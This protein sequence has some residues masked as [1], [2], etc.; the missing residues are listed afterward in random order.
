ML[1]VIIFSGNFIVGK[2]VTDTIPPF[3]LALL[4]SFIAFLCMIPIGFN[5]WKYF[6]P[7][8]GKEWKALFTMSLTGIV[9]FTGLVYSA[10]KHTTTINAAIVE[11]T[12]PVF[13]ILLGYIFLKE[14]FNKLQI[15]GT[16]LSLIGVIWIITKGSLEILQSLSF[17]VGDLVMLMAV[18][19]WAV[20]SL[21]VKRH[22]AKFPAYG[23]LLVMLFMATIILLPMAAIEWQNDIDIQ[24]N[25]S[26]ILG[27]L[28]VGFFPSILALIAWNK[29][30]GVIGPSRASVFLN[31]VPVFTT[32][33]A[34][35]FLDESLEWL[36][37]LGGLLVLIGV[38]LTTRRRMED[39]TGKPD[40]EHAKAELM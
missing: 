33:G 26:I 23:G 15:L 34:I 28:Y 24:W 21:L 38:Y 19:S 5:Q 40:E 29:A 8:W 22:N 27:L 18:I 13:A 35:L 37:V 32:I 9:L 4:R 20:Y 39:T 10:I 14:R 16:I 2:I 31:F 30:V 1:A 7:L 11:A 3:T 6:R 36:H 25:L 17:N 12:T